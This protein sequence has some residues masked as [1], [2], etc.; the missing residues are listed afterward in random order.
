MSMDNEEGLHTP[1]INTTASNWIHRGNVVYCLVFSEAEPLQLKI[2]KSKK[3]LQT[4]HFLVRA[5]DASGAHFEIIKVENNFQKYLTGLSIVIAQERAHFENV[6]L[7]SAI[8]TPGSYSKFRMVSK[9]FAISLD[10]SEYSPLAR[11]PRNAEYAYRA[12]KGASGG[13][14]LKGLSVERLNGESSGMKGREKGNR[15]R[16]I[17]EKKGGRGRIEPNRE[18]NPKKERKLKM[19]KVDSEVYT[20]RRDLINPSNLIQ[21]DALTLKQEL[22][23]IVHEYETNNLLAILTF[24]SIPFR[25]YNS[26]IEAILNLL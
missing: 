2:Q 12:E 26:I 13:A 18:M 8:S 9:N 24:K 4:G 19:R 17:A 10:R 23:I 6:I 11:T 7:V 16:A 21:E 20:V 5:A 15:R 14:K 3:L 1:Q 22:Q 25:L